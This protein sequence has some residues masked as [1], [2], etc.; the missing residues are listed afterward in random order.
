MKTLEQLSFTNN[1]DSLGKDFFEKIPPTPIIN[2]RLVVGSSDTADLIGLDP[3]EFKRTEFTEYFSG[4]RIFKNS[5]PIATIYAGHQ[6]GVWVPQLG[7]GRAILLGEL[8]TPSKSTFEI[9]LKGSGQTPFS[10]MGDGRAVLRSCIRE[11]LCS[12]AMHHLGIPTTRALCVI[13][14]DDAVERETL[15]AAAVLTRVAPTHIRFGTFE[16]FASRNQNEH[17]RRLADHVILKHFPNL[18]SRSD[19]YLTFLETVVDLTAKLIARWQAV[20]FAHGV[21][22]TDNMSVTGLTLDYGPFGFLEEFEP[23]LICN[24]SDHSGRY[25][26][27]QQPNIG[28][29][30][31][32]CFAQSLL[33]LISRE[34]VIAILDGYE[35]KFVTEY[36]SIMGNKLGLTNQQADDSELISE[37]LL[38]LQQSAADY[39]IFFRR[40]CD[41]DSVTDPHN[42]QLKGMLVDPNA[43]DLWAS[44]YRSRLSNQ[45]PTDR[46]K[47]MRRVNPKFILRNHLAQKAI[48]K[49]QEGDYSE[50]RKL[51]QILEIP[52]A[53]QPEFEEYSKP[54]PTGS[55]RIVV[56]CSS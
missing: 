31:L 29:W 10:R 21:L 3:S 25:A 17:L 56:S 41:F 51:S 8:E 2:P 53:D 6:F 46:P 23:S 30:N 13:E 27:H 50:V 39:T 49:A 14:A 37:I 35:E 48:E 55:P 44:R 33:S 38:Q 52:Y 11:F 42:W 1:Y 9:Q 20:G 47:D 45:A 34:E 22:N 54:A 5:E 43:F 16:L 19:R 15:E 18:L 40:L 4:N 36:F 28:L 12:E 26:F 24:H 32:S 7:D